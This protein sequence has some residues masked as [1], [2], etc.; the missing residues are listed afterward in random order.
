M[1]TKHE[2][3][4]QQIKTQ[5]FAHDNKNKCQ[6]KRNLSSPHVLFAASAIWF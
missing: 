4:Y 6:V 2:Q 1:D 3:S 5:I